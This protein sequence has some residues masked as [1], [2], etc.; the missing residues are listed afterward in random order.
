MI[1]DNGTAKKKRSITIMMCVQSS[2]SVYTRTIS[3]TTRRV[4][5][6]KKNRQK[7]FTENDFFFHLK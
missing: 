1:L 7:I 5:E 6:I 2:V 4:N 3:V